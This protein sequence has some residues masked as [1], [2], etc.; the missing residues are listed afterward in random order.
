MRAL[1]NPFT[2][3]HWNIRGINRKL[4]ELQ[5]FFSSN[6]LYPHTL[7]FFEHHLL[8]DEVY[9]IGIDKYVLGSCFSRSTF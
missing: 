9:S 2:L 7:C 1:K 5:E 3:I 6:N 8:R 4:E